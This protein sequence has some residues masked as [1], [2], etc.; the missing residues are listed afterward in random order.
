M[1]SANS[2]SKP[3]AVAR[4]GSEYISAKAAAR[5]PGGGGGGDGGGD[6]GDSGGDGDGGDGGDG[7]TRA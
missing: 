6:G 4:G 7:L 3:K 5:D 2:P 1:S